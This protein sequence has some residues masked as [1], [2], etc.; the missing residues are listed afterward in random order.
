MLPFLLPLI[1]SGIMFSSFLG[2]GILLN[3]ILFPKER[4]AWALQAAW[5]ISLTVAFGSIINYL[6]LISKEIIYAYL[7]IGLILFLYSLWRNINRSIILIKLSHLKFDKLF[8]T[9]I[10][11]SVIGIINLVESLWSYHFL[12]VDDFVGYFVFPIKMIATG[13]Y[14]M[15]PFNERRIISSLGGAPFLQAIILSTLRIENIKILDRGIGF[16]LL[17]PLIYQYIKKCD[18]SIGMTLISSALILVAVVAY[19]NITPYILHMSLFIGLVLSLDWLNNNANSTIINAIIIS[20]IISAICSLKSSLLPACVVMICVSY[21]IN[22]LTTGWKISEIVFTI[23]FT[24]VLL[25]IWMAPMYL[26]SG[27]F[28]YPLLGKGYHGSNFGI[29]QTPGSPSL[30]LLVEYAQELFLS[31]LYIG[32]IYLSTLYL[33]L[34]EDHLFGREP[35]LSMIVGSIVGS[36]TFFIAIGGHSTYYFVFPSIFATF[37]ILFIIVSSTIEHRINIKLC[38]HYGLLLII[39]SI[40]IVQH[41]GYFEGSLITSFQDLKKG[42]NHEP[43]IPADIADNYIKMQHAVPPG[44]LI[45]AYLDFP[46]L[47]NFQRNPIWV[48]DNPGGACLPPGMPFFRGEQPLTDYFK[49]IGIRYIAY[50]SP[51]KDDE[52]ERLLARHPWSRSLGLATRDFNENLTKIE[53]NYRKIYDDG[54][55]FV[56]DLRQAN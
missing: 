14:A 33:A 48:I 46:F 37:L 6:E 2:W 27:T 49:F 32:T 13:S 19:G 45:L 10:I 34:R 56:I 9:I 52:R 21:L 4:A 17:L 54:N 41:R 15:D 5:G 31:P 3:Y 8:L 29:I 38:L 12:S 50:N 40:I 35:I 16:L 43:L 26:S 20:L 18:L 47:L 51:N 1:W 39:V 53:S 11:F 30:H 23:I 44:A 36:I 25:M 7:L 55:L 28:M 22:I 42:F 24:I